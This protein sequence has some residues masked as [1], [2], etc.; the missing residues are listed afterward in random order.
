MFKG[1]YRCHES[2]NGQS[3]A[4]RLELSPDYASYMNVLNFIPGK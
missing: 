4:V 1:S 3:D 2:G